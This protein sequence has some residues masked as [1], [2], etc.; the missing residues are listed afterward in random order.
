MKGDGEVRLLRAE[1]AP[2]GPFAT[3]SQRDDLL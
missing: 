3:P 1:V 2:R